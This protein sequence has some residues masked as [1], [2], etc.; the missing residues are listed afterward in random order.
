MYQKVTRID[1]CGSMPHTTLL[2]SPSPVRHAAVKLFDLEPLRG[3]GSW[4]SEWNVIA[5]AEI[6]F[7]TVTQPM[8]Q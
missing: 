7:N 1:E 2:P 8:T 5:D 3:A 6:L 4:T